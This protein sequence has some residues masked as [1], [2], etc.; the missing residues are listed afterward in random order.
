MFK[1]LRD[2]LFSPSSLVNYKND[3]WWITALF[4]VML[5]VVSTIPSILYYLT[6]PKL[7]ENDSLTIRQEFEGLDLPFKIVDGE[8]IQAT[9]SSVDAVTVFVLDYYMVIITTNENYELGTTHPIFM[10]NKTNVTKIVDNKKKV[11]LEYRDY[12]ELNNLNFNNLSKGSYMQWDVVNSVINKELKS[13]SSAVAFVGIAQEF[14]VTFLIYL[15]LSLL[16]V[17]VNRLNFANI[18]FKTGWKLLIYCFAPYAFGE[19]LAGLYGISLF[20]FVGIVLTVFFATKVLR[21][22]YLERGK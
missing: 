1:R 16:L 6:P 11:V 13:S 14:L 15:I 4:F 18:D 12:P 21:K 5:V 8:L 9:S 19:L 17:L 3:K 7:T 10:I 2:A 22:V 20:S